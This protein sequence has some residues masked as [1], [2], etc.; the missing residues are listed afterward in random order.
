MNTF[1]HNRINNT[2]GDVTNVLAKTKSLNITSPLL[3]IPW[4]VFHELLQQD[5]VCV[6]HREEELYLFADH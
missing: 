4:H 1:V 3:Y 5:Y 2:W 6:I